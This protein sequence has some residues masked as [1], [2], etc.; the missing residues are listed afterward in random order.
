MTMKNVDTLRHRQRDTMYCHDTLESNGRF[1]CFYNA[2]DSSS[3]S[4]DVETHA[5]VIPTPL[6]S[7]SASQG[8]FTI[9]ESTV[10]RE[11]ESF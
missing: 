9:H 8:G 7:H 4:A 1:V 3:S 2:K 5:T 10:A 6:S 11:G